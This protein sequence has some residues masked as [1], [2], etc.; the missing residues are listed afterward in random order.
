M[1]VILG[2]SIHTIKENIEALVVASKQIGL[3]VNVEKTSVLGHFSRSECR[4]K[5]QYKAR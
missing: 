2:G 5:S 4:T 3:E 1:Y